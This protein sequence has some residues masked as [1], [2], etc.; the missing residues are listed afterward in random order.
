MTEDL[1]SS[2]AVGDPRSATAELG[3]EILSRATKGL[4]QL[5]EDVAKVEL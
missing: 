4:V 5:L 3:Q 1:N 2:G